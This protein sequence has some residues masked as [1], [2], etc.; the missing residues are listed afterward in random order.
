MG[1]QRGQRRGPGPLVSRWPAPPPG[2]RPGGL[3]PPGAGPA[4]PAPGP[5]L[6]VSDGPRRL[7][8]LGRLASSARWG[9]SA[10]SAW[11]RDCSLSMARAASR[12]SA[13]WPSSARWGA[14]AASPGTGTP[15]ARWPAPPPAPRGARARSGGGPARPAPRTGTARP[16][17]PAPPPAPREQGLGQVGG[18]RG[19]RRDRSSSSPMARAAARASAGWPSSAR[20]GASARAS[21]DPWPGPGPRVIDGPRRRQ[22]LGRAWS[23]SVGQVGGQRGQR[24][25]PGTTRLRWPAPP[26]APRGGPGPARSAPG[27]GPARPAPGPVPPSPM[28][29]AAARASAGWPSSARRRG[30]RGQRPGPVL[31][32]PDGPRR[33]QGLGRLA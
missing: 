29:R 22:R 6:L 15:R 30:Q 32:V 25:G 19:Q 5:V 33:L 14:S 16:R 2:P 13:G 18:Q 24:L 31:L 8:G 7:Q 4:R 20:R 9:A 26:P 28:A 3:A 21:G 1:G 23:R 17:W 11:D 27:G 12:A 10:A